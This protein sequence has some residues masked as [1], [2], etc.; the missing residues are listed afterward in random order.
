M[1]ELDPHVAEPQPAAPTVDP[2]DA[3]LADTMAPFAA[4]IPGAE[5]GGE[6][7]RFDDR[8][9]AIRNEIEKLGRPQGEAVDWSLVRDHG[10]AL[11]TEK[12]KDFLIAAYFTVGAYSGDGVSGLVEGLCA[13]NALLEHHWDTGFPPL[14]RLRARVNAID[15]CV[16]RLGLMQEQAGSTATRS[17]VQML[18]RAAKTL[19]ERVLERFEDDAPSIYGL[20]E[21][22]G[23]IER[24]VATEDEPP[25][26]APDASESH[27]TAAATGSA[28]SS[29]GA[30]ETPPAAPQPTAA[31]ESGS[32][33]E[34]LA[35][36]FA[37][38][39]PGAA[40]AG[41][42]ARYDDEHQAIRNEVEKLGNPTA[43]EVDWALVR[44]AGRTMLT[45][46]SKDFQIASYF[47]VGAY[48]TEGL[49]G[50]VSGI[51]A[52]STLVQR[53]W[54]DGF[55]PP[56]RIRA[57]VNA[58][59]W[60]VDRVAARVESH[61][62]AGVTR[63]Q[64]SLLSA[65]AQE[66]ER[67]VL[68]RFGDEPPNI[69]GLRETVQQFE[70]A[71]ASQSPAAAPA[72]PEAS[73]AQT[74]TAPTAAPSASPVELAAPKAELADPAEVRRFL[75][76]V[77]DS[78]YKAS[79]QLFN[80]S[81]EDP[82]AY[83]LCRQGLYLSFVQAPPT[84]D[85]HLTMVPAP[86]PDREHALNTMA[87]AQNWAALLEEAE[88]SLLRTRLWLD[89]HRYVAMAL[90]G[91]G[92]EAAREAVEAE[93]AA[94][95]RRLPDLPNLMFN[96]GQPFASTPTREWLATLSPSGGRPATADALEDGEPGAFEASLEEAHALAVAGS[97]GEAVQ[98]LTT[99]VESEAG[100]GRQRFLAR[101]AMADACSAGGAPALAEGILAGLC[102]DIERLGL[103][104]WE[105]K[106]AE[107]CYRSRYEALAARA[108]DSATSRDELIET[109][110]QL[111]GVAPAAALELGKPPG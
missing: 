6:N 7:A 59:D 68:D 34:E 74:A 23:H 21:T 30:G 18:G 87:G 103:Q 76:Q 91:L 9:E 32:R 100:S 43:G 41:E 66:L 52:L 42:N 97:L 35:R 101:L 48:T 60:F 44:D 84:T 31:H 89:V 4:P 36:P 16:E 17:E 40:P 24:S 69:Y 54:E 81:K 77:G 86:G 39:I 83:R 49:P 15:W 1:T 80:A 51:A 65:A 96:D 64:L 56:K 82:L 29:T 109:Y 26:E 93:T 13:M 99:V 5:P 25:V 71:T 11:L 33:L 94:L 2:I 55:P 53:Y 10:R 28:P 47:A 70:R 20:R 3:R 105:P 37:Q 79:R 108:G 27:A 73:S 46:R 106:L 57:R 38:P 62:P 22:I 78:L 95:V 98:K 88:S 12:S 67:V 58:I 72:P 75:Q 102:R 61:P 14:Q 63:E 92:H 45:T 107:R 90:G 8:H 50:L 104:E 85:G 111:C 110:R 19:E